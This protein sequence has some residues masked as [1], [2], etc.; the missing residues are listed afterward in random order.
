MKA[1]LANHDGDNDDGSD[2]D[3]DGDGAYKNVTKLKPGLTS[4]CFEWLSVQKEASK[5]LFKLSQATMV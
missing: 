5:K 1:S 3:G 2:G 4:A